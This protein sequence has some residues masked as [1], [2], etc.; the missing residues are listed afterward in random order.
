[1]LHPKSVEESHPI[2]S[3]CTGS[4]D[5]GITGVDKLSELDNC[6]MNSYLLL[7]P[8]FA[9]DYSVN[10]GLTFLL[11]NP[12]IGTKRHVSISFEV[13]YYE[14]EKPVFAHQR[15]GSSDKLPLIHQTTQTQVKM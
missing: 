10:F 5:N 11:L 3:C 12:M 1:M 2:K 6:V 4:N 9:L 7:V 15:A 14:P 13:C 8:S